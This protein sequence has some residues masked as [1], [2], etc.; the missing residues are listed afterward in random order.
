M[1]HPANGEGPLKTCGASDAPAEYG[2][3]KIR[4][5]KKKR[6]VT[7]VLNCLDLD[8]AF[9]ANSVAA[10]HSHPIKIKHEASKYTSVKKSGIFEGER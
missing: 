9:S 2:T 5:V 4:E 7:V 6:P 1:K 3:A 10:I 8:I